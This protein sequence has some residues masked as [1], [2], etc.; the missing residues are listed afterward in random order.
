[1]ARIYQEVDLKKWLQQFSLFAVVVI[2]LNINENW[3]NLNF[4]SIPSHSYDKTQ[5]KKL[6][7]TVKSSAGPLVYPLPQGLKVK[8]FKVEGN[9]KGKLNLENKEQGS[10][11][12]DDF[13]FRFGIVEQGKKRLGFFSRQIAPEWVLTLF[14]LAPK[15]AGISKVLFYNLYQGEEVSF[16]KRTHPLSEYLHEEIVLKHDE[17]KFILEKKF[18]NP[19]PVWGIWISSDGDATQS[20]FDVEVS[21]IEFN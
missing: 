4:S 17:G 21:K 2:P 6:K 10:K 19:I 7:W 12:A 8:S 3:I 1:M 18:E 13:R 9:I 15:K 20:K 14:K 5:T 11:G 16:K